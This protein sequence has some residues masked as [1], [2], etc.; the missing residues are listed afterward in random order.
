MADS[1]KPLIS[2]NRFR[3]SSSCSSKWRSNS[4]GTLLLILAEATRN[5][6]L[7]FFFRGRLKD[8]RRVVE[9]NE[10]SEQEKARAIRHPGR[11]LHVV[12]DDHDS[13]GFFEVKQ[14]LLDLSR[15]DWIESGTGLVQ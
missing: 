10:L 6:I 13:A 3:S 11:L 5:V 9:L 14:Q 8:D 12:G 1:T 4:E 7:G 2:S 15:S